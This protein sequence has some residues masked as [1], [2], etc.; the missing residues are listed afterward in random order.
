MASKLFLSHSSEDEKIVSNFVKFM[1]MIGLTEQ[2]IV[3]SSVP[4]TKIAIGENIYK[5]L[6]ELISNEDL[7]VIYF[8]SD[9]YYSSPICLNE[10]GAVW[11]KK[12]DSLNLLLPGFDFSDIQGVVEKNKVGIKLGTC[13]NMT[14]AAFNEFLEVLKERFGINPTPTHWEIAR[15]EFL[16]S[17]VENTRLFNMAFSRSYCIDDQDNE[18]CMII[19]RESSKDRI[20][21]IIDFEQTDSKLCS[22][23]IFNGHRNFTSYFLN[24]KKLCFEAYADAGIHCVDIELLLEDVD[25][26]Y[27]IYLDD[28]EKQF[29]IPLTQFCDILMFWK[30]VSELK[31]LF[32]RKKVNGKG[33]VVIKNLRIE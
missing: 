22:I 17:A 30:S 7:Y 28:D 6:N 20:T 29:Q 13:D 3:C 14:K 33:K 8:L 27:E 21:A 15:D 4:E 16:K 10:M 18:G 24:R 2:S 26:Q 12:S 31:F 25:V 5:Y 11:L 23:V 32:H 19:K 9:N 1:Y